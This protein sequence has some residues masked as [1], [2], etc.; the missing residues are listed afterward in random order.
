MKRFPLTFLVAFLSLF[1]AACGSDGLYRFTLV[2]E[3]EHILTQDLTSSLIVTDGSVTLPAGTMLDG[4]VHILSGSFNV[5]GHITGDVFFLNGDLTLGPS[6]RIGGDLNLGSGSYHPSPDSVIVGQINT[7]AGIPLPDLPEKQAPTVW[8][9]LLRTLISGSLLGLV[10]TV[11]I[12]YVPGAVGRVGEAATHHSLVSGAVGLLV[13]VVGI[14]LLVTMAY[15]ILLIPVT[16]LGFFLLGVAALYG[17]IGLGISAGR[18]GIRILKRPVKPSA[19]AFISMLVF[20]LMLELVSSIPLIGD[21]LGLSVVLIGLGA[22]ALTRFGLRRFTP[23][24]NQN[25]ST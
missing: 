1:L 21:L 5:D 10:A 23:A 14:S 20:M 9:L 3:G 22:V 11:L 25:L 4:S 18:L 17:W 16:L 24:A 2:T 6:A 8:I 13:G 15:T 19:A 12:R 7:G